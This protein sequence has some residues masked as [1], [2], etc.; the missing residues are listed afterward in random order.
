MISMAGESRIVIRH[1]ATLNIQ[2]A[3]WERPF[4]SHS[5]YNLF[6]FEGDM[7]RRKQVNEGR[8]K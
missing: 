1:N 4:E 6:S 2:T 7:I 5:I 3:I 8:V